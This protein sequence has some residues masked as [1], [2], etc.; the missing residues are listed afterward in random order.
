MQPIIPVVTPEQQ[1][2][3][4][5]AQ[6]DTTTAPAKVGGSASTITSE[7]MKGI[8][9]VPLAT[10]TNK[11]AD[12]TSSITQVAADLAAQNTLAQQEADRLRNEGK[13]Q[14]KEV[15]AMQALLGGRA[16]FEAQTYEA[17][18]VNKVYNQIADLNAQA[19]GLLNEAK[20]IPIQ[21]QNEFKGTGA[22]DAGVAPI[23]TARL[24]D[25]ALKAL[26]LGQQAAIANAQYDKAKN[27]A[28]QLVNAK[29]DQIQADITAK[30]TN[31]Q[32]L[33]DFDLSPA[34]EKARL[35]REERLKAEELANEDKRTN[36]KALSDLVIKAIAQGAPASITSKAQELARKGASEAEVAGALGVYA[37][38]YLDTQI[39]RAQLDKLGLDIRK[40]NQELAGDGAGLRSLSAE[41]FTRFNATPQAKGVRDA[42]NYARAV[43]NYREAI[44]KYGTGEVFGQGSGAL[45]E[46]YSSLV[47]ATKDY[48]TLGTYDNGVEKLIGIGIPA[49]S[50]YGLKE[51]RVSALDSA[52]KTAKEKITADGQ[53]LIKSRYGNSEELA[54]LLEGSSEIFMEEQSM[55]EFLSNLPG[56]SNGV[57]NADFFGA[58]VNSSTKQN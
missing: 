11:A 27:Y 48:Y 28:D 39:K 53:Q 58:P 26:S 18:G 57:G 33:K 24:R 4:Y 15:A 3:N 36:E 29:Y 56:G 40:G 31:L 43:K 25:N 13:S 9:P 12:Y 54:S 42:T 1:K 52:L 16:G 46:A 22:T 55:D 45:N 32:A 8:T 35:A 49:P 17:Q 2:A 20:A 19:T 30:L 23:E 14:S 10:P 6:N 50:I 37:G 51:G 7:Q 21:I 47:G 38:D 34:Q 41:E 44:N 5:A